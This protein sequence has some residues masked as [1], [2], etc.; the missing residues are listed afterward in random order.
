MRNKKTFTSPRV[1]QAVEVLLEEN[2]LQGS[3]DIYQST[4]D[5]MGTERKTEDFSATENTWYD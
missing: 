2:L 5:S 1:L 3:K 4:V